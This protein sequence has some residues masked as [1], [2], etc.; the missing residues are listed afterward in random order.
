MMDKPDKKFE[1]IRE[2]V[3]KEDNVLSVTE[4]CR[5]AG[6]SR[7]GYY[8]WGNAEDVRRAREKGEQ[9]GFSLVFQA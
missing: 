4:L 5:I 3:N 7:S 2:I 8:R 6:V 1:L 9:G